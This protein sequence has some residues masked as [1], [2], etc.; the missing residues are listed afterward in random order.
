M[1]EIRV[2][3]GSVGALSRSYRFLFISP[4]GRKDKGAFWALFYKGIIPFMT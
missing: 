1:S 3:H 4:H 2:Q